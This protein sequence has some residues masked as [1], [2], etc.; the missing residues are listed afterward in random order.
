LA[1]SPSGWFGALAADATKQKPKT[2]SCILLWMDGGPCQFHTWDVKPGGDYKA[3]D[4]TVPGSQISEYLPKMAQQMKNVSIVRSMT[5]GEAVH[6]RARI[7]MH[8][9]YKQLASAAYPSLG[10]LVSHEL[11]KAD[12]ELPNFVC[13][14]GGAKG[15]KYRP[16]PAYLGP[17]HAPLMVSDP[18]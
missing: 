9:G 13:V 10:C 2:K 1:A 14:E 11:G 8:T 12:F 16:G 3:I 4:T 6:D 5:T 7:L 15:S 17:K 18:A